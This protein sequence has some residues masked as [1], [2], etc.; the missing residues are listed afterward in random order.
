MFNR[1]RNF[2]DPKKAAEDAAVVD[3]LNSTQAMISFLP[4]GTILHAND[5]FLTAMGYT[6][7]EVEGR[8]HRM[9]CRHDYVSSSEYADFWKR[10]AAG[11][12]H[13]D[14][15][16][17]IQKDG[18][19]I[20]IYATYAAVRDPSNAVVKVVKIAQDITE[21]KRAME[22]FQEALEQLGAGNSGARV[23]LES[24]NP[25]YQVARNFNDAMDSIEKE[26]LDLKGQAETVANDA[27]ARKQRNTDMMD[28]TTAQEERIGE[29]SSLT[30]AVAETLGRT[31]TTVQAA[32]D[33]LNPAMTS[34]ENGQELIEAARNTTQSLE[35]KAKSMSDIN[36]MIDDLSF[37]TNLLAL[38]AGVEA[39][40]AGEAGA[41]FSVVA[42][43][44]RSLAQQSSSASAQINDLIRETT[45][46][47][48]RAAEDVGAGSEAFSKI[49][50]ELV[51]LQEAFEPVVGE[52]SEQV[53]QTNR[54][55]KSASESL[56]SVVADRDAG[57]KNVKAIEEQIT[58]LNEFCDRLSGIAHQFS[59]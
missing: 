7:A 25:F 44:I 58:I 40:R 20:W 35:T 48:S 5:V 52:L 45:Q 59:A 53:S 8:H 18:S 56:K 24:G 54:V 43:E 12:P 57:M 42:S 4:D 17:R 6:A 39:A 21:R 16:E 19:S 13:T 37:Q 31:E 14:E 22:Q 55:E 23:E 41:G 50:G 27:V 30:A 3:M 38:N 33:R 9:F 11:E 49:K 32:M 36:R 1:I 47:S 28:R 51:A 10:L 15:F 29:M 2:N 34:I 26:V 46:T